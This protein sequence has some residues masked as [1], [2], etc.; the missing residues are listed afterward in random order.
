[1]AP[2]PQKLAQDF[3]SIL[4]Q[5][6]VTAFQNGLEDALLAGSD[7]ASN[8]F[9]S[10][11][12][13][14][15]NLVCASQKPPLTI[16][17]P[18]TSEWIESNRDAVHSCLDRPARSSEGKDI[19]LEK[20]I[21]LAK[22]PQIVAII[23]ENNIKN[24]KTDNR[25]Y[26][27]TTYAGLLAQQNHYD[28]A[29]LALHNWLQKALE[30]QKKN[31]AEFALKW[32]IIRARFALSIYLEEWV[33]SQ[34]ENAPLALRQ[35]HIDNFAALVYEMRSIPKLSKLQKESSDYVLNI[36]LLTASH[37]GDDAVCAIAESDRKILGKAY[38]SYLSALSYLIDNALKH[39]TYRQQHATVI[40]GYVRDLIKLSLK[41][42]NSEVPKEP[43]RAE[44]LDR[45][46]RNQLNL[47]D[48]AAPLRSLDA[49][50]SE[51]RNAGEVLTLALQLLTR[52]R[53]EELGSK[54]NSPDFLRRI[55][56]ND[57]I[58]LYDNLILT[59]TKL[60]SREK[61]LARE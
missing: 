39:P 32:S 22:S 8:A 29:A 48:N 17:T 6:A 1:V 14:L 2:K 60:Q 5:V 26:L 43:F 15:I 24:W 11:C 57:L 30:K 58:E 42:L 36:G 45:Y 31:S 35:Y 56:S 25:P 52:Q 3:A 49:I 12:I 27:T 10:E 33:R 4:N 53:S 28:S 38:E 21:E 54:Q 47:I 41:C 44:I 9:V 20:A 51:L 37:S 50:R 61:E 34:G 59:K 7:G 18:M 16:K 46:V 13:P 19:E 55:Y 40:E 23:T